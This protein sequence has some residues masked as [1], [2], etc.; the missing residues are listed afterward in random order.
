MEHVLERHNVLLFYFFW[1]LQICA[2]HSGISNM[3]VCQEM[4]SP[5]TDGSYDWIAK[6]LKKVEYENSNHINRVLSR[7]YTWHYN[8]SRWCSRQRYTRCY[9]MNIVLERNWQQIILRMR[10]N[11]FVWLKVKVFE[12]IYV[13]VIEHCSVSGLK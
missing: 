11:M 10:N 1:N 7:K 5:W 9:N 12:L 4:S 2:Q 3:E 13:I 8:K 6:F